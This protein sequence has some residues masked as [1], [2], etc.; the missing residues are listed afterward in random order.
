MNTANGKLISVRLDGRTVRPNPRNNLKGTA[1][2][3]DGT[4]G[5]IPLKDGVVSKDGV[6]L[7]DDS[8]S[9]ILQDDGMVA[10]RESAEQDIYVFAFGENHIGAVQAL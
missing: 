2:T 7:L 9:L 6:A 5:P 8:K 4:F 1:R 10:A 3:L